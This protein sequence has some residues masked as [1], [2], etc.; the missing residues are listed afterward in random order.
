MDILPYKA[1]FWLGGIGLSWFN[2]YIIKI[3]KNK[4]KVEHSMD[5][6]DIAIFFVLTIFGNIFLRDNLLFYDFF[7][8]ATINVI[9]VVLLNLLG[10]YIKKILKDKLYQK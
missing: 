9:I 10:N 2:I 8:M 5:I 7:I 1:G 3:I 6:F 4:L